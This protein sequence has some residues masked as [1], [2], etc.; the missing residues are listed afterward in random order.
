MATLQFTLL[1]LLLLQSSYACRY[2]CKNIATN[3]YHCCDNQHITTAATTTGGYGG[4]NPGDDGPNPGDDGANSGDDGANPGDDGDGSGD[5][6]AVKV[7]VT[8]HGT[9]DG[10]K[11]NVSSSCRYYCAYGGSVYCC[12]DGSLTMPGDHDPHGGRCPSELEQLCKGD[13]IYLSLKARKAGR[14]LS[15]GEELSKLGDGAV[16]CASDGYCAEDEKCCTSMCHKRHVCLKTLH[17]VPETK[18]KQ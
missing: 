12:D 4:P 15:G 9:Q 14:T 3:T 5:D 18:T 8:E 16:M 1:A 6:G 17:S 10:A 13:N 11:Y 7:L 2:F